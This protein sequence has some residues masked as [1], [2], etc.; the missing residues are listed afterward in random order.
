MILNAPEKRTIVDVLDHHHYQI[1]YYQREYRWT[2]TN[3][4]DLV[5]DL[6]TRFEQEYSENSTLGDVPEMSEYFLGTLVLCVGGGKRKIVD[7][8]QRLSTLSLLLIYLHHAQVAVGIDTE[9]SGTDVRSLIFTTSH[10]VK[11]YNID[12]PERRVVM[13]DLYRGR[14]ELAPESQADP[15]AKNILLRFE[16]IKANFPENISNNAS[17]LMVFIDW[18]KTKCM[19]VVLSANTDEDAVTIFETMNDRGLSLTSTEMLN[20]YLSNHVEKQDRT[21]IAKA[22]KDMV[23]DLT[24]R[25]GDNADAEF[26]K[27]FLRAQYAIDQRERKKG[28]EPKDYENIGAK[29]HRWVRDHVAEIGLR[30]SAD[31]LGWIEKDLRFFTKWY[32]FLMNASEKRDVRVPCVHYLYVAGFTLQYMALLAPLVPTDDEDTVLKKIRITSAYLD[33][34]IT[35]KLWNYSSVSY[36][37]IQYSVFLLVRQIRRKS[38]TELQSILRQLF[39]KEVEQWSLDNVP[40]LNRFTKKPIRRILARIADWMDQQA[41]LD[42]NAWKYDL[43]LTWDI[44]HIWADRPEYHKECTDRKDFDE[45][46][47]NLGALSL[48]DPSRNKSVQDQP[49]EKKIEVYGRDSS[50]LQQFM[51][52][53][54]YRNNPGLNRIKAKVPSLKPFPQF[55]KPE[56]E[57]RG[58]ILSDIAKI[59]WS[60]DCLD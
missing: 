48:L 24:D 47:N 2:N 12:V 5:N 6:T 57:Q 43:Y 15:S 45:R 44:E 39:D 20:A 31:F 40:V 8:Q 21:R 28:G 41:G 49:Y 30:T 29:Y 35:R 22:L 53:D 56:V 50:F 7:G 4:I 17:E 1:D 60:A 37:S 55:N 13:D 34:W 36:S 58:K 33:T 52:P 27:N 54:C 14:F 42:S 10:G 18:L 46:R 3:I 59:I 19:F 25:I 51:N 11:S 38:L 23:R 26:Y 16:D 9:E 32:L